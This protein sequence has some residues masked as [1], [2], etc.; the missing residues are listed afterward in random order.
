MNST[1]AIM[2]GRRH[3][4]LRT[5]HAPFL[6]LRALGVA[7]LALLVL[8]SV[9]VAALSLGSQPVAPEPVAWTHV[10]V[11]PYASLWDLAVSHPVEGLGAAETVELI[12]AQNALTSTTLRVGQTLLV[13]ADASDESAFARR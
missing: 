11:A 5:K 3:V 6:S 2:T 10:S 7:A 12:L 9:A 1:L 4:A 13:P 8:A